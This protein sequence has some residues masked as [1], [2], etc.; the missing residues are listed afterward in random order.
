MTEPQ[1]VTVRGARFAVLQNAL[2]Y[3][4]LHPCGQEVPDGW[5]AT[6][7]TGAEADCIHYVDER[8][9]AET[10]RHTHLSQRG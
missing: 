6:G 10:S 4:G 5:R 2:G 9:T 1:E 7:F 8:W 3:F